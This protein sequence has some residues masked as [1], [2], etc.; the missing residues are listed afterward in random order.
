MARKGTGA[1]EALRDLAEQICLYKKWNARAFRAQSDAFF[2]ARGHM[3][4]DDMPCGHVV[5]LTRAVFVA[6]DENMETMSAFIQCPTCKNKAA[7]MS[8]WPSVL[9]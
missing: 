3:F 1:V 5:S 9:A 4:V 8:L 2:G 6:V 7:E